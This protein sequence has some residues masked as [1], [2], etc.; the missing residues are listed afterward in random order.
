MRQSIQNQNHINNLTHRSVPWWTDELTTLRKKTNAHRR[1]YQRTKNNEELRE[2][3]K[4]LY[5]E[6][7]AHYA[8]TIQREKIK[9]W[10]KYCDITTTANPWNE[11]YKLAANKRKR[12]ATHNPPE[13]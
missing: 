12:H 8:A 1:R 2:R 3:R 5:A 9:S 10:K 6:S 4:N 11:I 13:T 7:K